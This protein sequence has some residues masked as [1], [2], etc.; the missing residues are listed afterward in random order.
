[1]NDEF[2]AR[3]RA[4]ARRLAGCPVLQICRVLGRTEVWFHKWRCHYLD[5]GV[6][7]LFDLT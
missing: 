3:R 5:F 2:T 7:G 6:E 1:M 4:I